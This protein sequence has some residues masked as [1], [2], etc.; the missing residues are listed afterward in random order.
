MNTDKIVKVV[1]PDKRENKYWALWY[2]TFEMRDG[3]KY[4]A[5]MNEDNYKLLVKGK[6]LLE[7]GVPIKDLE[8]FEEC[9][10]DVMRRE[11]AD[12]NAG[13]DL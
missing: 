4:E 6:K 2:V 1:K 3:V 5:C 10:R 13:A 8:E 11:E 12:N 9:V 7:N